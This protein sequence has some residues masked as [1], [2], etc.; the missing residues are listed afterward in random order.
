MRGCAKLIWISRPLVGLT[1]EKTI[2]KRLSPFIHGSATNVR[3][4]STRLHLK[5]MRRDTNLCWTLLVFCKDFASNQKFLS[6]TSSTRRVFSAQECP[7]LVQTSICEVKCSGIA[8]PAFDDCQ[9]KLM[10]NVHF[11]QKWSRLASHPNISETTACQLNHVKT[12]KKG[13]VFGGK[14]STSKKKV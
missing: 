4:R 3:Q 2:C 1:Q 9:I 12:L 11:I 7:V 6:A 14:S 5:Q 10:S 13:Q 8:L